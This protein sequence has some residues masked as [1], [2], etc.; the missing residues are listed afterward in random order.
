MTPDDIDPIAGTPAS[1]TVI[2]RM[3]SGPRSRRRAYHRRPEAAGTRH[4]VGR[5][6][7][8][9]ETEWRP[10]SVTMRHLLA[11]YVSSFSR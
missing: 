2:S 11:E 4:P 3:K 10:N 7:P 5:I 9:G 1:P 8:D 6:G